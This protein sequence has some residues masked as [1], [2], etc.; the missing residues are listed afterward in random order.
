M[1]RYHTPCMPAEVVHY[2]NGRRGQTIVDG[3]LG[4]GGHARM[5]SSQIAPDG[6]LIGIDQ[7]KD[8]IDHARNNLARY[9]SRVKLIHANF[10]DLDHILDDLG[11]ARV[12]GVLLDIGLSRHQLQESGR[13]FSFSRNEP[14]DMR[15]NTD[16]PTA[17]ADIVQT[18]DEQTLA[19]LFRDYGE[20]RRA[21]TLARAIVRER[22]H[23]DL[24]RSRNLADLITRIVP[25]REAAKSKIHPATRVFMALR[26]AVNRELDRLRQALPVAIER[27]VP[28]GRLC[29]LSFHSLED[30]IV[31]HTFREMSL[32]CRCD[33]RLPACTC[34]GRPRVR[35]LT[36]RVARPE[37]AEIE[38]NPLARST[39]LRAVEKLGQVQEEDPP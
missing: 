2:L 30:R 35:L 34:Q 33:P 1:A 28:G 17:A 25:R 21:R 5:I 6:L 29:V 32:G 18:A 4:G 13:G 27:L 7:D 20:E 37:A 36:R 3:T 19:R 11:I 16:D 12:D 31:K 9:D 15:M 38:A 10:A 24:T 22:G 39:R 14:L 8:A 26:I 23:I